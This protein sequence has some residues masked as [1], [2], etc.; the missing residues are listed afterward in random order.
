MSYALFRMFK[1]F[2]ELRIKH[3]TQSHFEPTPDPQTDRHID[4]KSPL[5]RENNLFDKIIK[6]VY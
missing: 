2:Q 6:K 5:A 3:K 1:D 4:P